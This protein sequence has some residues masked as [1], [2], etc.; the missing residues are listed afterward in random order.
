MNSPI[1]NIVIISA[2]TEELKFIHNDKRLTWTQCS[3]LPPELRAKESRYGNFRIISVHANDKMGLT[4]SGILT[5]RALLALSPDIAIMTGVCAGM[6][7]NDVKI[8]DIVI[9]ERSFHFQFGAYEDGRVNP[10]IR[11]SKVPDSLVRN[12]KDFTT[13]AYLGKVYGEVPHGMPKSKYALQA[14]FGPMAS[15]DFVVKD[16]DKLQEAH[17]RDRKLR[18][19]D[20][21]SYAFLR[22][23]EL[24]GVN[25]CVIKSASDYADA[26]KGRGLDGQLRPYSIYTA[27]T[28]A[29]DFVLDAYCRPSPY[30]NDDDG[31]SR[32]TGQTGTTVSAPF[33]AFDWVANQMVLIPSGKATYTN[34]KGQK[35]HLGQSTKLWVCKYPVT[36]EQYQ[37]VVGHNP[38]KF[39]GKDRPVEMVSWIDAVTFCNELSIKCGLQ[40]AYSING[41][42]PV[43]NLNASGFRL[44]NKCEWQY[45]AVAGMTEDD[46]LD[47]A[48]FNVNSRSETHDVST[49]NPN[50][51]GIFHMLGNVWEW[52]NDAC[53][54]DKKH[55][56][57]GSFASFK[58]N[59]KPIYGECKFLTE[60]SNHIGFRIFRSHLDK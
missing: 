13:E 6:K 12:L 18:G 16:Q 38:S 43:V 19:V 60:K 28:L 50:R 5:T 59:V 8:G 35:I 48:W 4:E 14:H 20:M 49:L 10:E 23:A 58:N 41:A 44:P 40:P 31:S 3:D 42:I 34:T 47:M 55:V 54:A 51:F 33:N 24:L 22:A 9:S 11:E 37:Q 2:L 56:L 52:C 53:S 57:G 45:V 25:A 46:L 27:S 21:E 26:K 36:Q 1:S 17:K 39:S 7:K 30:H 29:L 32:P 15:S